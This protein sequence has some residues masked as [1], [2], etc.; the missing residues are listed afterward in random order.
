[1]GI[2]GCSPGLTVATG[3]PY[4]LMAALRA[5]AVY[6]MFLGVRAGWDQWGIHWDPLGSLGIPSGV[7]WDPLGSIGISWDPTW[8]PSM[9][10]ETAKLQL[11]MFT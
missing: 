2:S 3:G 7:T 4:E 10:A 9:M 5:H 11:N 1:M 6:L 8:D